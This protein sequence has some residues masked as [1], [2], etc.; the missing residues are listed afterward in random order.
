MA[1]DFLSAKFPPYVL[2]EDTTAVRYKKYY[3]KSDDT[4]QL[5]LDMSIYSNPSEAG[6]Y[7]FS[8]THTEEFRYNVDSLQ[9]N[10]VDT[11]CNNA[12]E[13]FDKFP[14][15]TL[16]SDSIYDDGIAGDTKFDELVATANIPDYG[17]SYSM[18]IFIDEIR[19]LVNLF[20]SNDKKITTIAS[21][22]TALWRKLYAADTKQKTYAMSGYTGDNIRDLL[23]IWSTIDFRQYRYLLESLYVYVKLVH[24][25]RN[26]VKDIINYM[27]RMARTMVDLSRKICA[28]EIVDCKKINAELINL[29]LTITINGLNLTRVLFTSDLKDNRRYVLCTLSRVYEDGTWVYKPVYH[30]P[31]MI[32]RTV[33]KFSTVTLFEKSIYGY[34]KSDFTRVPQSMFDTHQVWF[35][36]EE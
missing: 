1:T 27:E 3:T 23:C 6:L 8:N 4:Y 34:R 32:E 15:S 25:V 19:Q 2:T 7:E 24:S 10:N 11:V 28:V 31:I 30:D 12:L 33:I 5:V 16:P 21:T 22:I 36:V 13:Y 14:K 26:R 20:A 35:I 17:V 29:P 9:V 18:M